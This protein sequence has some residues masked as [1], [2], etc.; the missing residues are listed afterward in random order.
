[1]TRR[2][3]SAKPRSNLFLQ[4]LDFFAQPR[5][6]LAFL[7]TLE[8]VAVAR[9]RAIRPS[10]LYVGIGEV[11]D[12]RWIIIGNFDRALQLL[13]RLRILTFLIIDPAKAVDVKTIV[14]LNFERPLDEIF[15]VIKLH[16][17]L[18]PRVAKI[19]K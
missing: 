14:G 8:R 9:Q 4:A 12:D 17:H 18:S 10:D 6:L 15:R 2:R 1:M 16:A 13:D 3:R 19:V 7:S 11:L 5:D